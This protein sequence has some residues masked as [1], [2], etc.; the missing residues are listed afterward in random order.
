MQ[1]YHRFFAEQLGD[2]EKRDLSNSRRSYT[3]MEMDDV[4]EGQQDKEL[5]EAFN[6]VTEFAQQTAVAMGADPATMALL[7]HTALLI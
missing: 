2:F 5:R 4:I 1:M 6:H 3:Q 7:P